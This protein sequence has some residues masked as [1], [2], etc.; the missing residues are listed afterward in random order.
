MFICFAQAES[1]KKNSYS[2]RIYFSIYKSFAFT[3]FS[4][5]LGFFSFQYIS[6][7]MSVVFKSSTKKYPL[8]LWQNIFWT[9]KKWNS[10]DGQMEYRATEVF[11]YLLFL[12]VKRSQFQLTFHRILLF[13]FFW[14]NGSY[15]ST[16]WCQCHRTNKHRF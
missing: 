14:W 12:I 2:I 6:A 5:C 1:R 9:W 13:F 4:V 10:D 7:F 11:L 16:F 3:C 15:T 8:G